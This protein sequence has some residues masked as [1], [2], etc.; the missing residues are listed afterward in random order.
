MELILFLA[1]FSS[2][3]S[4]LCFAGLIVVYVFYY[5]FCVRCIDSKIVR[6]LS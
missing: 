1:F 6:I 5:L 3:S 2:R 4:A